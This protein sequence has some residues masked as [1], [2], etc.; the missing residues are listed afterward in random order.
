VN[1]AV[2]RA[3]ITVSADGSGIVSQAGAVLLTKTLSVTGLDQGLLAGL[4]RWRAPRAVH[5][6]A[7][8]VADLTIALALGGDCVAGVEAAHQR[9]GRSLA[10][11]PDLG[12]AQPVQAGT[13][14]VVP[15]RPPGPGAAATATRQQPRGK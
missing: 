9:A 7:K 12:R 2:R 10:T 11:P 1:N 3:K 4:Q 5:D 8:I 6:P 14:S 15:C 13:H